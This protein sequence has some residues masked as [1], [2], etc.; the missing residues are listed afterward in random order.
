[1][2]V[3]KDRTLE[4][5]RQR[6][7]RALDR[8]EKVAGLLSG[9]RQTVAPAEVA[10]LKAERDRLQAKLK[11]IEQSYAELQKVTRLVAGRLDGAIGR[12]RGLT[13]G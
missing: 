13:Q 10:A 2:R 12:V 3:A 5:A 1:M 11:E 9:R 6:L 4:A 8:L 7:D